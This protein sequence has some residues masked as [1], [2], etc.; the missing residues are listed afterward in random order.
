[1]KKYVV[2]VDTTDASYSSTYIHIDIGDEEAKEIERLAAAKDITLER[3]LRDYVERRY[4]DGHYDDNESWTAH[5]DESR[6][7]EE[8]DTIEEVTE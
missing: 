6:D 2:K 1:M 3:S 7:Y 5:W 4:M 8:I